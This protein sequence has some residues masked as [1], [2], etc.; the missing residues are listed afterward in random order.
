MD[1]IIAAKEFGF[2]SCY[3]FKKEIINITQSTKWVN[4][5][6]IEN[7]ALR[8]KNREEVKKLEIQGGKQ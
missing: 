4:I 8:G 3:D 1:P 6:T 7:L 2:G 5:S